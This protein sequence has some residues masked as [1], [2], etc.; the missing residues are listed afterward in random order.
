MAEGTKKS[1]LPAS[2]NRGEPKGK[3]I[4]EI[5]HYYNNIGV[6]VIALKKGL[7]KGDNIVIAGRGME[8]EQTVSS[9]QVEHEEVEKAKPGDDVGLKVDQAVKEGDAVYLKA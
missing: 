7:A 5:T 9:M 3:Q 1:E 4:G 8:F 6:G 2:T